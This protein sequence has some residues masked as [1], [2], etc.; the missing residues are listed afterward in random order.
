[1]Q[2]KGWKGLSL[3]VS[4][5]AFAC[6]CSSSIE[7]PPQAPEVIVAAPPVRLGT[8]V[9]GVSVDPEIARTCDLPSSHFDFDSADLR[10]S[11]EHLDRVATCFSRGPLAGR[12]LTLVGHADSRGETEYN[13][14]LGHR[15]AG[16]VAE[17]IQSRGVHPAQ[18][19]TTSRGEID[20]IGTDDA[21]WARD[22]RVDVV[23]TD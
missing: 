5:A 17:Y 6:G 14:A 1:M 20:A 8:M 10:A 11:A 3:L 19:A 12:K 13:F 4:I 9:G 18:V 22:R 23:L 16:T 21:G 15:R 2:I 7:T